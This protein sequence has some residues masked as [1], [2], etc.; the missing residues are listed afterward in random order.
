[1]PK[2]TSQHMLLSLIQT[3]SDSGAPSNSWRED[4]NQIS[5]DCTEEAT[6]KFKGLDLSDRVPEELWTEVRDIVQEAGIK[7]IPKWV[8]GHIT[9]NKASRGDGI[10]AEL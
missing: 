6:N 8:L 2:L 10:P 5:Y 9:T 4:L 3:V 7:T 1:M